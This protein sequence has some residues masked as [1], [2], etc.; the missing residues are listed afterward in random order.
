MSDVRGVK[1][2]LAMGGK[3][4]L[5]TA[6][7]WTVA[8]A[9]H[10][11]VFGAPVPGEPDAEGNETLRYPTMAVYANRAWDSVRFADAGVE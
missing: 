6:F 3:Q 2:R 4:R 5:G 11:V 8:D 10:L 9:G 7:G 1:V